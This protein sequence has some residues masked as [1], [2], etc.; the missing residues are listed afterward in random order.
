MVSEKIIFFNLCQTRIDSKGKVVLF[1]AHSAQLDKIFWGVL[2]IQHDFF[3]FFFC[4]F[5]INGQDFFF[6]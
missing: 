5:S 2:F 3:S 6:I 4:S 1:F